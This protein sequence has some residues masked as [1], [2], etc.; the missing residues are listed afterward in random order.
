MKIVLY[1]D[2][3]HEASEALRASK[4][5]SVLHDMYQFLRSNVKHGDGSLSG[6]YDELI[7]LLKSENINLFE[8]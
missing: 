1:F 5:H 4:Y 7:D 8:E 2:D 6:A 3:L